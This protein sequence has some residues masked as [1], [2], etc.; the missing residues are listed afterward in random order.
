MRY[1]R[2]LFENK[3]HYGALEDRDGEPWIARLIDAP[4]EDLRYRLEHGGTAPSSSDSSSFTPIT[5]RTADLLAPV[6]PS[7]IVCVGRN[8]RDHV[9]ELGHD[10]PSEPLLFLKPPSALLKPNGV[11]CMPTASARVDYEGELALVIGRRTR[12]LK[13]EDWR[14]ALRG[15]T[16]ADDVTARD[17]QNKDGQWTRAKGFDTFCPVGP[18]VSDELDLEAGLTL[19][20]RVNT[21]RRTAGHWKDMMDLI[22]QS[23]WKFGQG[24]RRNH[25]P[26]TLIFTKRGWGHSMGFPLW[27]HA[28]QSGYPSPGYDGRSDAT[29]SRPPWA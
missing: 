6:T 8:Y 16:L 25:H 24:I 26:G 14:S 18:F 17:L 21:A 7:K 5:L 27:R 10:L 19:E 2:F 22:A 23:K 28:L 1:C 9:K 4:E 12:N 13:E 11:V 20:T 29:P 3:T 15:V